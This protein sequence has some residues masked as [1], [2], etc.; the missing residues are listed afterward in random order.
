[1]TR[2]AVALQTERL[3][4]RQARADDVEAIWSYRSLPEVARFQSWARFD[5]ADALRLVEEQDGL[6]P[7][8]AGTWF[9]LVILDRA[10]SSLIGDLALHFRK[11]DHRQV[12]IGINLAPAQQGRGYAAEAIRCVL[13]YLFGQLG[14]HRVVAVTDAANDAA[15]RVF[16]NVGFRQEG[17]FVEHVWFKGSYGSE[18]LF[19]LLCGEW[20][21]SSA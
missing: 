17:H 16:R 11:D 14:K 1:M 15:A 9:Q 5:R 20:R 10:S 18:Y 7:D 6:A 3:A 12:E 21:N 13:G 19:A 8:T 4:L 2:L